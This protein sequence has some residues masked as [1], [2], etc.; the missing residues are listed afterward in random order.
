MKRIKLSEKINRVLATTQERV[1]LLNEMGIFTVQDFLEYYPRTHEMQNQVKSLHEIRGDQKNILT[2]QFSSLTTS[3]GR[4]GISVTKALFTDA[5]GES[6]EAAWFN[7]PYI[8]KTLPLGRMVVVS[9]KVKMDYGK[10]TLQNPVFADQEAI[11]SDIAP[12]YRVHDKLSSDWFRKK[13]FHLLDL[14]EKFPE[15]IPED[16]KKEE[17]LMP[18]NEAV[19][20]IHFPENEQKLE[21]AKKTLAFE[22]LFLLQVAG[23][24]RKQ[25]WQAETEG[26]SKKIPLDPD[27]QKK[28]FATLPF[29]L[30]G[31]Q[32]IALFEI[33]RDFEGDFPALRLLEGDVGSGKTVVAVAAS[34]PVLAQKMQVAFLAPTEV[35]V[36]QHYKSISA[37]LQNFDPKIEV[38]LLTGAIKGKAREEILEGMRKGKIQVVVGTHALIQEKVVWHNLG[39]CVIDEQHRFGVEQREILLKQG[40]P[41]ILQMTATPIPRTLAIVAFGDQDLS[42]I[43]ELPAGRKPIIT[44]VISPKARRQTELFIES[45]VKKGQQAFVICPLVE[46]SENIEAKAATEEFERLRKDVFPS[47]RLCLLHGRMS[48]KEKK[49]KMEAFSAGEYDILVSTAVVEVG[50]DVPNAVLMLI[51]GAERFGLA[52]L[53]QFRGR[54]GRA[55]HQSYCFLFPTDEVGASQRLKAMEKYNDGFR[56]AEIDLHL[57]GPGEVFGVRQSGIPDLKIASLF[58]ARIIASARKHAEKFIQETE[59]ENWNP[60]LETALKNK[61]KEDIKRA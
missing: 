52:Q 25:R 48:S 16:I 50:V 55:D 58:D 17:D 2:G 38:A 41:H 47:L 21:K 29:E 27:L 32:K 43:S 13:M 54:V 1:K 28:F 20:Q 7:Q 18:K 8:Q 46:G 4:S 23:V 33:L 9:A 42:I 59:Q 31:G 57:R 61:E 34:L 10:I 15:I 35:L 30:T 26:K 45:E 51:E 3:R 24:L 14:A 56:L 44:K 39:F 49:E 37:L 53:H 40:Y 6:V 5:N 12:I 11:N 36:N 22:E 19:S 60:A